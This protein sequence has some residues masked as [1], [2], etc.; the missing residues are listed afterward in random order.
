L[1]EH[2]DPGYDP[3]DSPRLLSEEV[4]ALEAALIKKTLARCRTHEEAAHRLGISLST[5]TR[6]LRKVNN[7]SQY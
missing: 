5:L 2:A 3:L 4:E 6:R 1:S 7:D